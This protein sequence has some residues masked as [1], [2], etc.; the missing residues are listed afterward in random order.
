M[1]VI[2]IFGRLT[3]DPE[4][5]LLPH[6]G[7]SVT[8]FSLA[9]NHGKDKDNKDKVDFF[10]C[11]AFGKQADMIFNSCKK[12][13]RLNVS[14]RFES[15]QYTNNS[16]QSATSLEVS[17]QAFDFVEVKEQAAPQQARPA[18]A[19]VP[20]QTAPQPQTYQDPRTG[21]W[22]QA[23]NGQWVPMQQAMPPVAP[24][25]NPVQYGPP[26]G[27]LPANERPF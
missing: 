2:H 27:A 8:S 22:Y 1:A 9:D 14:G 13:H 26:I 12:G 4:T 24:A 17:V 25:P 16:G 18:T 7:G 11:S 10:R 23:V 19:P 20:V 6:N 5:K 3:G 21:M 15:R